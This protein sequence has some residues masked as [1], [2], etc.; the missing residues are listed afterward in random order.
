M[1]SILVAII[2]G[3]VIALLLSVMRSRDDADK[4]TAAYVI[5]V[6][7]VA[8]PVIYLGLTYLAANGGVQAG[9]AATGGSSTLAMNTG[10]PD[11]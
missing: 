10:Y 1:N 9:G 8:C 11:F 4:G 2:L 3:I 6:M 5:K 7:I